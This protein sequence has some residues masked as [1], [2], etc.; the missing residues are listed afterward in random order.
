MI[1][2]GVAWGLRHLSALVRKQFEMDRPLGRCLSRTIDRH[3]YIV[4]DAR[5]RRQAIRLR[6]HSSVLWL[7]GWLVPQDWNVGDASID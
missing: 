1:K 2:K 6:Y 4:D 7:L 5:E 3:Q